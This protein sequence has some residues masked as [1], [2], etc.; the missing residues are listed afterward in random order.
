MYGG[1]TG[2]AGV[3]DSVVE[4]GFTLLGDGLPSYEE[5]LTHPT[6]D[7]TAPNPYPNQVYKLFPNQTSG[8]SL[9]F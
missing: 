8:I 4:G 1:T 9:F 5:A 3:C 7:G 6:H 2:S